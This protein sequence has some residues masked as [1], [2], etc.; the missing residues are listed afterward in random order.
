MSRILVVEDEEHIASGLRFNLRNAGYEVVAV[1][2]G[3]EAVAARSGEPFDLILLDVMLPGPLSG[4]DVARA[5]RRAEDYTP[6]IMLTAR[7]L[8]EDRVAG[9]D[10]GADDYV[11][12][13][14]DLDELLAR[15]RANLRRRSW[16]RSSAANGHAPPAREPGQVFEFGQGCRVDFQSYRA[17]TVDGREVELSQ[18]ELAIMKLF[19]ERAGEVLTRAKLL[20]EV[21][22]APATLETRTMDNFMMRLRRYFEK[23]PAHPEHIVSVR[24]AGYRFV[25]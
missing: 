4:Y 5:F 3:E 12:K 14:F 17:R 19:S 21:W 13:P 1:R 18:K 23:D 15:V 24:G 8:R 9:M 7:D 2:T 6:I 16:T 22:G 20:E 25:R 10:S 11:V